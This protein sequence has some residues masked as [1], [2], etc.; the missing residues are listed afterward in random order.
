ML[1]FSLEG[2]LLRTK[3]PQCPSEP[4]MPPNWRLA[5]FFCGL[6]ELVLGWELEVRDPSVIFTGRKHKALH[7][8]CFLRNPCL[9]H[10]QV[11]NYYTGSPPQPSV[12]LVRNWWDRGAVSRFG[13]SYSSFGERFKPSALG[14]G[15]GPANSKS[16]Q[17]KEH[18]CLLPALLLANNR[19]IK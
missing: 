17:Q 5:A 13:K 11:L 9:N 18:L 3:V 16:Q 4:S 14:L 7:F 10:C 6:D 8:L 19:Q 12:V 15:P 2:L 1:L